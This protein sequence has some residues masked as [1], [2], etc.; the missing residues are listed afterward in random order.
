VSIAYVGIDPGKTGAIAIIEESSRM[1]LD[2]P[3][4][5]GDYNFYQMLRILERAKDRN[6]KLYLT[7]ER[8]QA[9][10]GQGVSSTFQTGRGYGA[11]EAICSI[12]VPD[13]QIVS[14]RVW[15]NK[16]GLSK[17]KEASRALAIFLYP[18]MEETLSRKKDHNR[19]E[20]LLLAHYT[21]LTREDG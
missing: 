2:V 14:P 18:S 11:W 19:A 15:K 17:D 6:S 8:Q 21:K 4:I 16:L 10:P 9:M 3:A 20:A 1:V 7:L 5:N 12:T 13:F